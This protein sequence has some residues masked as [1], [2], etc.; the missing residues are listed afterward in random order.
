[1]DSLI[2]SIGLHNIEIDK[3]YIFYVRQ[4]LEYNKK[5]ISFY[6]RLLFNSRYVTNV[7]YREKVKKYDKFDP[8]SISYRRDYVEKVTTME[9]KLSNLSNCNSL[10]L[11]N[12]YDEVKVKDFLKTNLCHDRFCSNC[13]KVKQASRMA[14][15]IPEIAKYKDYSLYHL[16]LTLPNVCGDDL[17]ATVDLMQK[18]FTKLINY[19]K[20]KKGSVIRGLDFSKFHY[21]GAI[22]SLEVTFN[23]ESFHPHFHALLCLDYELGEKTHVNAYSKKFG[24][25]VRYFSDFEILIQKIWYL[26]IN[27]QTVNLSNITHIDKVRQKL[28]EDRVDDLGY[29]CSMD[30]FTQDHYFELFKYMTKAETENGQVFSYE[31]FLHLYF[32]LKSKRQ[33]QGYGCFFRIKDIDMENEIDLEYDKYIEALNFFDTPR[34]STEK[35]ED[36]YLDNEYLLISRK[37]VTSYI[38]SINKHEKEKEGLPPSL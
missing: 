24:K 8:D 18:S 1:M 17:R 2:D 19:L 32:Q 15:F 16:T 34:V 22:R 6:K 26:L 14:R 31:N 23:R 25:I 5:V 7:G 10:W 12:V 30:R 4:N 27:K 38:R 13:K 21:L 3:D 29:S 37:K 28:G 36:L 33:I 9:N 20:C 11:L 35:T